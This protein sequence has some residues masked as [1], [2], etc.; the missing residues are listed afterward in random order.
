MNQTN[1]ILLIAAILYVCLMAVAFKFPRT[2]E[3]WNKERK[4]SLQIVMSATVFLMLFFLLW[5][6]SSV[7]DWPDA[8]VIIVWVC[9]FTFIG[10]VMVGIF[11]PEGVKLRFD[12]KKDVKTPDD[13]D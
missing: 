13:D 2:R 11:A 4:E 6:V 10:L 12:K 1:W 9:G 7:V 8:V 5:Y 3:N